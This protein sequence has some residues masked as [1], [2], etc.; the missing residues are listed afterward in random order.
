MAGEL[1]GATLTN[2]SGRFDY[3]PS[4]TEEALNNAAELFNCLGIEVTGTKFYPPK[5]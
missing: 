1:D 3:G 5:S 4:I 2:H